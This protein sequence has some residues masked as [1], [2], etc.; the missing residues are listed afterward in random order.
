MKKLVFLVFLLPSVA[1]ATPLKGSISSMRWQNIIADRY[2]LERMTN[3]AMVKKYIA[4]GKLVPVANQGAH[5]FVD[6]HLGELDTENKH[7]YRHAR[8]FTREFILKF[9]ADYH[10]KFSKRIKVTSLVRTEWYQRRLRRINRNAAPA[11]NELR[12]A[13]LTGATVDISFEEMSSD[14]M[15]WIEHE[16]KSLMRKNKLYAIKERTGG[17]YHIM[18]FPSY[19][20]KSPPKKRPPSRKASAGQGR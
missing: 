10:S 4:K 14:E 15:K 1:L 17:C 13:H 18:V 9:S 2:R 20:K 8:P 16:L 11:R 5:Y 12:S 3:L 7:Y 19:A 6:E